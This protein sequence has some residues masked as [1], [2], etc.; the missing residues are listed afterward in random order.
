MR[1]LL[2]GCAVAAM[3]AAWAHAGGGAP[4][5]Q[6]H[7]DTAPNIY[8]SPGWAPWWAAAKTDM[9]AGTF[10][11]MRSGAYPGT[12]YMQ[13]QEFIVYSTPDLGYRLHT[14][15]WIPGETIASLTGRFQVRY[16]L[17]WGGVDY[18]YN[19]DLGDYVA[20]DGVGGTA[21]WVTPGTSWEDTGTGVAGNPGWAWWAIDDDAPPYDSGGSA[22]DE[23]DA[24]DVEALAR[25][26]RSAQT[27]FR[28]EIRTRATPL[29]AWGN[30]DAVQV[31]IRQPELSLVAK[32][33]CVN[34]T[35][36]LFVS[37]QINNDAEAW[38]AGVQ[39]I[40]DFDDS[41]LSFV[42]ATAEG[43]FSQ[44]VYGPLLSGNTVAFANG[45]PGGGP[46]VN[47]VGTVTVAMLEFMPLPGSSGCDIADLV[48]FGTMGG[49]Y[50][51]ITDDSATEILHEEIGIGEVTIDLIAPMLVGVP[52]NVVTPCDAGETYA[53]VPLTPP[54]ATDNLVCGDPVVTLEITYP[55]MVVD[56]ELPAG[57][58]Y[59]IGT[60]TIVWTATDE[61]GNWSTD[62]TTV[63]VTNTQTLNLDITL[64][65]TVNAV[66]HTR[67]V[68]VRWGAGA[69]FAD[70][71]VS[72][73]GDS[74]SATVT[75]APA[76]SYSCITV[77]DSLHTLADAVTPVISMG[78]YEASAYLTQG[79]SN[80]DNKIDILDFGQFVGDFGPAA[81]N[82]RSNFNADLVVDN[83]DFTFI[84]GN[85]FTV[86]E[87][88]GGF[89][90]G[91][92]APRD[93]ISVRELHK[94]KMPNLAKADLN[95]D[96]WVDIADIVQFMQGQ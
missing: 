31:N 90:A 1:G 88:C 96:G 51:S 14:L 3:A 4:T 74:G 40:V 33:T 69:L 42:G 46:E 23:T 18:I 45:V 19:F 11:D 77:K 35:Q 66:A 56:D 26:I 62:T 80:N 93:R 78:D 60:T 15:Y 73:V 72:F 55:S 20:Y 21:G 92:D 6:L 57:D 94:L 24:A 36:N 70:V 58:Q 52:G 71:P 75:I 50:S 82:G 7:A 65:P 43:P 41:K 30:Y 27:Y 95:G 59:P 86:G 5:V 16:C 64:S 25:L 47:P 29:D 53:T 17:D 68:R 32:D 81:I 87:S 54:T 79:D 85:F 37:V 67:T 34:G 9:E 13:P 76:G 12:L 22:Y 84:S 83:G 2:L 49:F 48:T 28:L 63:T 61:C 38:M 89:L 39:T 91:D 10:V 44:V 8:G